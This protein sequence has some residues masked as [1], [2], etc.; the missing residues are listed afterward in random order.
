MDRSHC[1]VITQSRVY[2]VVPVTWLQ[3][4]ENQITKIFYSPN[5]NDNADFSLPVK[6]FVN[7]NEKAV[8]N[9]YILRFMRKC[10]LY[11]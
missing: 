2:L 5:E 6:Y 7:K 4:K 8:Y 9:A 10:I 11:K 1:G 3:N